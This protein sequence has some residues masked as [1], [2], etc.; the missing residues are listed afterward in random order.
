MNKH[1]QITLFIILGLVLLLTVV[2]SVALFT[3]F[4]DFRPPGDQ[5]ITHI[6]TELQ[7]LLMLVEQCQAGIAEEALSTLL[8]QGGYLNPELQGIFSG[9][10]PTGTGLPLD[11]ENVIAYWHYIR[12]GELQ[13]SQPPLYGTSARSVSQQVA[14]YIDQ[15]LDDCVAWDVLPS[16]EITA[17]QPV[18][19]LEFRQGQTDVITRWDI[20][21]QTTTGTVRFD[22]FTATIDAPVEL[23]FN[24]A[25]ELITEF[26]EYRVP[27]LRTLDWLALYATGTNDLPPLAGGLQNTFRINVYPL[28]PAQNDLSDVLHY[29][30]E[31]L[32]VIDSRD[33]QIFQVEDSE[34]IND[35]YL[36]GL[37]TLDAPVEDM[38]IRFST[39]QDFG[40]RLLVDGNPGV[41]VPTITKPPGPL[42]WMMPPIV[43]YTFSYDIT[44]PLLVTLEQNGYILN[45]G[46][47]VNIRN[48][49]PMGFSE[50]HPEEEGS[51]CSLAGGVELELLVAP[52]D[53]PASATY[54]C[55]GI[56]CAL[57]EVIDGRLE[58][59]LPTCA[60]GTL[61]VYA[62]DLYADVVSLSSQADDAPITQNVQL[63]EEREVTV[64]VEERE[65]RRSIEGDFELSDNSLLTAADVILIRQGSPYVVIPDESGKA[66][67]VP[68]T[69]DVFVIK[70]LEYPE[71][72][73]FII[74]AERRCEDAG[75]IG[76]LITSSD[77]RCADIPQINFSALPVVYL[78]LSGNNGL[79][80]PQVPE[81]LV[82]RAAGFNPANM[83]V[84]EDTEY[85]GA[86]FELAETITPQEAARFEG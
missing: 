52:A 20:Q 24:A 44:Y 48:N 65:V 22:S 67:M 3:D 8:S 80:V 33:W 29:Q 72:A 25:D 73:P 81:T 76:N 18:S 71:D 19:R 61:N 34:A 17:Q 75:F 53:Q 10:P 86:L 16:Y 68:G 40:L 41:A 7:P 43:D 50:Q 66:L 69:Y 27:E 11:D 28:G 58:T 26:Q 85:I 32:Q 5:V 15:R 36:Q 83:L 46:Y 1:A 64:R 51:Y 54:T 82:L 70:I 79:F 35:L 42:A 60:Q 57:G 59:T 74:P 45:F 13:S 31:S 78:E 47:E 39:S 2:L 9:Y 49:L 12:N 14:I 6:P 56:T 55:G 38:K 30:A 21:A 23:M 77:D 84:V 4:I 37:L 63:F 62:E